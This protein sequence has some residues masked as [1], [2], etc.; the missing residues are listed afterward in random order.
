MLQLNSALNTL[1]D[2]IRINYIKYGNPDLRKATASFWKWTSLEKTIN[3]KIL[4]SNKNVLGRV[5]VFQLPFAV[6]L[7]KDPKPRI[8][9][10]VGHWRMTKVATN[11]IWHECVVLMVKGIWE[12]WFR[13]LWSLS[14]T[15]YWSTYTLLGYEHWLISTWED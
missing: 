10:G 12:L 5:I 11:G 14:K 1:F 8:Q 7:I 15:T 9:M 13:S 3:T 4:A 2:S 6:Y